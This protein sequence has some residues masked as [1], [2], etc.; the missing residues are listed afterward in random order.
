MKKLTSKQIAVLRTLQDAKHDSHSNPLLT[1]TEIGT[2]NGK[3]YHQASSWACSALKSLHERGAVDGR[4]GIYE[5]TEWG[6]K[7]LEDGKA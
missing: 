3:D 1:P 4:G 2:K 5:I 6:E 7:A